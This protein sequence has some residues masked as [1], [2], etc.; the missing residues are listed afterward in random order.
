MSFLSIVRRFS[1]PIHHLCLLS[2]LELIPAAENQRIERAHTFLYQTSPLHSLLLFCICCIVDGVPPSSLFS[3][4]MLTVSR[5]LPNVSTICASATLIFLLDSFN[6][7]QC[8]RC[9]PGIRF[10][11]AL[12]RK[13]PDLTNS[14]FL[15]SLLML[16]M[17]LYLAG[18]RDAVLRLHRGARG[19]Q[20][21]RR[22]IHCGRSGVFPSHQ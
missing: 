13:N 14:F 9:R 17:I 11:P 3:Y 5:L 15:C 1:L 19:E 7:R 12:H 2:V 21:Q 10:P 22:E 8:R 4:P 18:R 16:F 6:P 20:N